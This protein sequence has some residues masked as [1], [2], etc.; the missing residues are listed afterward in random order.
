MLPNGM[1]KQGE[2]VSIGIKKTSKQL[3]GKAKHLSVKTLSKRNVKLPQTDEA[4]DSILAVIGLAILTSL[5]QLIG[6]RKK[7]RF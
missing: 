4:N 3:T 1:V 7:N 5:F 2:S 6:I